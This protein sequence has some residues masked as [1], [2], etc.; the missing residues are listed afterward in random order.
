M[1]A[2]IDV[3]DQGK[4]SATLYRTNITSPV[5]GAQMQA[6]QGARGFPMGAYID[7]RDQGKRSATPYCAAYSHPYIA[8]TCLPITVIVCLS[9]IHALVATAGL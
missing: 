3:R 2:Y 7:V 5:K 6:R 8:K 4:R 9:K 1:G